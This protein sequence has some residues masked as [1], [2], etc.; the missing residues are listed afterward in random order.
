M[1]FSCPRRF[2][3]KENADVWRG[4]STCSYCGSTKPAKILDEIRKRAVTIGP[5]DKNYKIYLEYPDRRT[6]KAYFQH[7]SADERK[8]FLELLN[9]KTMQIG[10]PKHFYVLPYFARVLESD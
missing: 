8:E 1:S 6:K 2:L 9:N 3:P 4:D 5:T 10:Y 7:F